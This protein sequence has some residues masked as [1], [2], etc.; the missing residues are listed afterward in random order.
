[1]EH[2]NEKNR[3]ENA[4][5]PADKFLIVFDGV[6]HLCNGFVN[7]L[8]RHDKHD[9][10]LFATLQLVENLSLQPEIET[11]ISSRD[12]I[13]FI[14]EGKIYFRSQAVLLILKKLGGGW[15]LFYGLIIFPGPFRD[16]V[17]DVVAKNRYQWFGRKDVC[18]VP[19]ERARK[20][21]IGL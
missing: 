3:T 13:A 14:T 17:Y 5:I 10:F 9:R 16:W 11:K 4:G 18:M 1:V 21:F 6:C 15:K 19:D 12:S 2:N 20:K 7:F 8:I